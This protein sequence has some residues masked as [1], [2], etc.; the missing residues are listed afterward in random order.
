M[1]LAQIFTKILYSP[2]I[3]GRCLLWR[4]PLT[5]W[6]Q[7]SNQHISE[8]NVCD[9]TWVKMPPL[10]CEIKH[11]APAVTLTF[12]LTTVCPRPRH[13]C[14]FVSVKLA[15]IFTK[16]LYLPGFSGHCLLWPRPL[17]AKANQHYETKYIC[18]KNWVKLPS[19]VCETWCRPPA[20]TLTFWP[21]QYVAGTGTYVT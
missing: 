19:L 11:P 20:V 21:D 4:W 15:Q 13:I 17:I 7:K 2:D 3:L 9:Q 8:S 6:S 14:D 12:D 5:L 1:K 10:L 18:D 16:I